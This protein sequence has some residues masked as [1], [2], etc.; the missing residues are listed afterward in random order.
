MEN[1]P[2][3]IVSTSVQTLIRIFQAFET[4][5]YRPLNPKNTYLITNLQKNFHEMLGL[6]KTGPLVTSREGDVS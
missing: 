6:K 4:F 5:I 2:Y 1:G 3:P